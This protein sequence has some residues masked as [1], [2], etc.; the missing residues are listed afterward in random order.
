VEL[1]SAPGELRRRQ[2]LERLRIDPAL[3]LGAGGEAVVYAV[4]GEL[5][6]KLYHQP[7]LERARKLSL[8]LANP[9]R[10]PAGTAIA[11][12]VDLL[13]DARGAFA[14]FLMPRAEGPRVFEFYNPVSRRETA[15]GFHPGLLHRAGRNLAAAFAALHAA[16]Y[17]VGDVNESNFLVSPA[18]G[19]VTLVDA[20][21]LQVADG[22]AGTLFRSRVGKAEFTPP[23]LQGVSFGEVDRGWQ[24]DAF[25][26]AV[27][28]YLL[29]MEG[30]HPFA[31]RMDAAAEASPVQERIRAGRFPHTTP[32]DDCHPPRLSPRFDALDPELQTL[33]VRAFG[34]G[35][36]APLVRPTAAEWCDA[37]EQAEARLVACAANP[38]HRHAP[39]LTACPWCERARLLGGRDPFPQHAT[40]RPRRRPTRP[41][42]SLRRPTPAGPVSSARGTGV[43]AWSAP[44]AFIAAAPVASGANGVSVQ[45]LFGP[46]GLRNPVVPLI[47]ALLVAGNSTGV[48]QLVAGVVAMWAATLLAIRRGRNIDLFTV[49]LVLALSAVAAVVMRI[50]NA[51]NAAATSGAD[52]WQL[53]RPETTQVSWTGSPRSRS[54]TISPR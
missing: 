39:H 18:D 38:L 51:A 5:V 15:P 53:D 40:A 4:T 46:S 31:A 27:V 24:H 20:D 47:P 23:E 35:H 7:T 22:A 6:A 37:L 49:L 26:L 43:P 45:A 1:Q 44:T 9:P 3:E 25:G 42:V 33:F 32:D 54:P 12:P 2:T 52:A 11:W 13:M 28:I 34:D 29:L 14:G 21:S 16:G 30:T 8:M 50:S 36:T 17:V 19:S 48:V 10:M 41:R